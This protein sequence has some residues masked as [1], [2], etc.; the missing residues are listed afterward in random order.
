MGLQLGDDCCSIETAV[1]KCEEDACNL[2][3]SNLSDSNDGLIFSDEYN[4]DSYNDLSPCCIYHPRVNLSE[5]CIIMY[6]QLNLFPHSG[7]S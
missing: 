4:F 7:R 5:L 6:T 3:N 2:L 1:K